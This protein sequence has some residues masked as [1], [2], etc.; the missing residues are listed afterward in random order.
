MRR[1]YLSRSW[2]DAVISTRC[3]HRPGGGGCAYRPGRTPPGVARRS[4]GGPMTVALPSET[5]FLATAELKRIGGRPPQ[6]PVLRNLPGRIARGPGTAPVPGSS[7]R[8]RGSAD[9][10]AEQPA[11]ERGDLGDLR[12]D[13]RQAVGEDLG[14]VPGGSASRWRA[15][16]ADAS[17]GQRTPS[18]RPASQGVGGVQ[19]V[20]AL[21][22]RR[23]LMNMILITVADTHRSRR[24]TSNGVSR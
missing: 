2:G 7:Q 19:H 14:L 11:A 8:P 20:A 16:A 10:A 1:Q 15:G 13:Q 5:I 17:M 21:P 22:Q 24:G 23:F 12:D 4:T 18:H 9:A 3:C 6:R